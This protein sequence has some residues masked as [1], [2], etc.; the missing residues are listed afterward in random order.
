METMKLR[1]SIPRIAVAAIASV[2]L[3]T[4]VAAQQKPAAPQAPAPSPAALLMAKEIIEMKGATET[5]DPLIAGVIGHHRNILMQTNPNLSRPLQEV[6]EKLIRDLASRRIELQQELA[7]TYASYFTEQELR[8]ALAFY[9][10]P[11]GKKLV[12]EEP[13]AMDAAFK[14]ADEWSSNFAKEVVQRI[15]DEMKKRGHNMI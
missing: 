6:A 11:L 9:R 14:R 10:T 13:K 7:R 3:M 2:A 12:T 8:E 15:R 1:L 5:F 4:A